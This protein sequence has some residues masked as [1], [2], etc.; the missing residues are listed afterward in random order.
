MKLIKLTIFLFIPVILFF[1]CLKVN[2]NVIINKDCMVI[3]E[4]DGLMS[5]MVI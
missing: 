1:G 3:L 5:D 2:S 4:E